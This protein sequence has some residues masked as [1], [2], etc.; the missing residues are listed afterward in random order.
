LKPTSPSLTALLLAVLTALLTFP[1]SP[2]T[3]QWTSHG[4]YGGGTIR[5]FMVQDTLVWIGDASRGVYRST[6]SHL[7]AWQPANYNGLPTGRI[8]AITAMGSGI[9]VGTE[10]QGVFISTDQGSSWTASGDGLPQGIVGALGYSGVNLVASVGS[11]IYL[12]PGSGTPWTEVTTPWVDGCNELMA[13]GTDLY[14][15]NDG[16]GVYRSTDHGHTWVPDRNGLYGNSLSVVS[17]AHDGTRL[18]ASTYGGLYAKAIAGTQWA[19]FDTGL[20]YLAYDI[21]A[22]GDTLYAATDYGVARSP[23]DTAAWGPTGHTSRSIAVVAANGMVIAGA[24]PSAGGI[25]KRPADGSLA[26][27]PSNAGFNALDTWTVF[28]DGNLVAAATATGLQV[29][30]DQGQSFAAAD[31][32][33]VYSEYISSI[34]AWRGNLYAATFYGDV[35]MSADSG[36]TWT[37]AG[38]Q[39]N[40]SYI[41]AFAGTEDALFALSGQYVVYRLPVGDSIWI[42]DQNLPAA[43]WL[44][45]MVSDGRSVYV[46]TERRV[47]K[48]TD[49]TQWKT[50]G[51]DS[52]ADILSI[53]VHHG[54]VFAS[55]D[56]QGGLHRVDTSG[57]SWEPVGAGL[58][59]DRTYILWA[60]GSVVAA[61]YTGGMMVSYDD[62]ATWV[63]PSTQ[64]VLPEFAMVRDLHFTAATDR[65]FMATEHGGVY[66]IALQD[67][68]SPFTAPTTGCGSLQLWPNPNAGAFHVHLHD[69]DTDVQAIR[70]FDAAGRLLHAMDPQAGEVTVE[71]DM[72]LAPGVYMVQAVTAEGKEACRFVVR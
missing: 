52:G 39:F 63:A 35:F 44:T 13:L 36:R 18:F 17:L 65:I 41:T 29:S 37:R 2:A 72:D 25:L 43:Q 14:A 40:F 70:V 30:R 46:A 33:I 21:I 66:S 24:E 34:T 3:A 45:D 48:T 55:V 71:V 20:P 15:A 56:A 51:N 31:S 19:H 38:N 50:V 49:G 7:N 4:P 47:Y 53:A 69:A 16:Y 26:W 54:H 68:S 61:A 67:I 12:S 10:D 42:E 59:E 8:S 57:G 60:A 1:S 23:T 28:A 58:P 11:K 62:G 22:Y 5:D 64:A 32:G 6:D 27:A 9:A